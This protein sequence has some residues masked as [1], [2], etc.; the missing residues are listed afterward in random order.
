MEQEFNAGP[1]EL[2]VV[3]SGLHPENYLRVCQVIQRIPDEDGSYES[4]WWLCEF[5]RPIKTHLGWLPIACVQDQDLRR[6]GLRTPQFRYP[7]HHYT[8]IPSVQR[9]LQTSSPKQA[10][11]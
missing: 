4:N 9:C 5:P 3:V 11:A 6:V 7:P 10:S 1:G 8:L 2:A